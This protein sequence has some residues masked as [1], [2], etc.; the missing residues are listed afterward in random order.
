MD[1]REH[2]VHKRGGEVVE[3]ILVD[4]PVLTVDHLVEREALKHVDVLKIDTE[5]HDYD[6]LLGAS[7]TLQASKATLVLFE[8]NSF[9]PKDTP[10]LKALHKAVLMME[11]YEYVCYL[12]GKNALLRLSHGCWDDRLDKR[13]WSN[14]W[15]ASNNVVEGVSLIRALDSFSLAFMV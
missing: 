7:K 15:C 5:G 3:A 11:K 14:V 1:D 12:E 10:T 9:W 6:V 13:Q 8:F 4:V 2:A